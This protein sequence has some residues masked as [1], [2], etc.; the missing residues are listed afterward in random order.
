ML[1]S[2]LRA[3]VKNLVKESFNIIFMENEK[4]CQNINC[5]LFFSYKNFL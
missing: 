2:A 1:M 5:F 3:L 4:N